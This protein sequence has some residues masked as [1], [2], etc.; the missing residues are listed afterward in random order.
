MKIMT[1]KSID[2]YLCKHKK[3]FGYSTK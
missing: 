1:V 3:Y 2:R